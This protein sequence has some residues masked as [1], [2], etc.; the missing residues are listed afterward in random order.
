MADASILCID[1][2]QVYL[3]LGL[4]STSG[5]GFQDSRRGR[6]QW[7]LVVLL[8]YLHNYY[9]MMAPELCLM[10]LLLNCKL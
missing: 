1:V 6:G 9:L 4:S 8:F 5:P 2:V 7:L 3:C 10:G